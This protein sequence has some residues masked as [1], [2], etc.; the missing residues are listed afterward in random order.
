MAAIHD[1]PAGFSPS[2]DRGVDYF[3]PGHRGI[4]R[5]A[6]DRCIAA[7]TPYDLELEQITALGRRIWVRTIGQ[8]ERDAQGRIV[9]VQ[10]AFQEISTRKRAQ[11]ALLESKE[12]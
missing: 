7:G 10:G 1:E 5:A 11:Q 2:L 6:F 12:H 9:R 4:L 8:A 3:V